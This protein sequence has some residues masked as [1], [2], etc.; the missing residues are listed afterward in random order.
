[1]LYT[2]KNENNLKEY[3]D[4]NFDYKMRIILADFII[5]WNL[6]EKN[7]Y[8]IAIKKYDNQPNFTESVYNYICN[9]YIYF[10]E[11]NK[12][13]LNQLYFKLEIYM[14]K[15]RGMKKYHLNYKDFI[16]F[17]HSDKNQTLEIWFKNI[18]SSD[19]LFT[20]VLKAQI[21]LYAV[22]RVRNNLF[23]GTKSM[24]KIEEQ[25]ELFEIC[26]N[27]LSLFVGYEYKR[28]MEQFVTTQK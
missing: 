26:N 18:N 17:F 16:K 3:L 28:T 14:A 25:Y 19:T 15:R 10:D 23:H 7:I 11:E 21:M 8:D 1:M 13:Q 22:M 27:I 12:K 24:Y 6:Y 2:S 4:N 20:S 5:L 9:E